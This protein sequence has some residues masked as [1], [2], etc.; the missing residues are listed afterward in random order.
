M[1]HF[2]E[3]GVIILL[4]V[5]FTAFIPC[6]PA[7]TQTIINT[8]SLPSNNLSTLPGLNMNTLEG[9]QPYHEANIINRDSSGNGPTKPDLRTKFNRS[10]SEGLI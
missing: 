6:T 10:S 2:R 8:F 1:I 4:I 7:K 3:I 5:L 9:P